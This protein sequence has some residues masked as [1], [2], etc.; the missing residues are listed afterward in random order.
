MQSAVRCGWR[1]VSRGLPVAVGL[2]LAIAGAPAPA[3]ADDVLTPEI[4][5]ASG[6]PEHVVAKR[7]RKAEAVAGS[8]RPSITTKGLEK[9]QLGARWSATAT[10]GPGLTQGD[11]TVLTW[12]IVPDGTSIFGYAGE[13]T[14]ASNLQADLNGI[15][16]NQATWL[17]LFQQV[18]DR[19]SDLTG[20]TYVYEPN[21][22]GSPWTQTSIAGGVLG[23][24]GDVRIAGHAIDGTNGIL[25]YN[26][27]PNI[28]DMVIDT[29]DNNFLNTAN[30]SRLLRNVVAHEH[31]HGM[32]MS[33]VCPVNQT[34]LMEPFLSLAFDGPQ[35]DDIHGAQRHYGDS[36][37][38]NDTAGTATNLG[39]F[40][41]SDSLQIPWRSVDD[42]SDVN[43]LA[44]SVGAFNSV[45][46]N[47]QPV[48]ATYLQGPQN[49]NGTCTAGTSFNSLTIHDLG[50]EV[51][52]TDGV[53]VLAV[54]NANP[55]GQPE[56]LSNLS[57]PSGSG[58]YFLRTFGGATNNAQLY[59]L[60]LSVDGPVCGNGVLESGEVCDGAD[61]GGQTCVSQGF[62][63]GVLS[64]NAGCSAFVTS[65]CFDCREGRSRGRLNQ[66]S[67]TTNGAAKGTHY[68]AIG[69]PAY[70]LSATLVETSAAG[71]TL[72][73]TMW[74][75]LG[76]TALYTFSGGWTRT[77]ANTGT[78]WAYIY[79]IVTN[80]Q[81]GKMS[82]TWTDDPSLQIGGT[83]DGSWK[84]C[85]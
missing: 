40:N 80:A 37:E 36:F 68:D 50:F 79:D 65:G 23:V 60:D 21:D 82:G 6:T 64:C 49:A 39:A 42:N 41:P 2:W 81:V 78:Y 29:A 62:D 24:R 57:L 16:G 1:R 48:G 32:G 83:F 12:S 30:N 17:A 73:G 85:D 31:G 66:A 8:L 34:K 76:T 38:H 33:H 46:V 5:F 14:A 19:W 26:F 69:N 44:F 27:F 11:P 55:A 52:D 70:T 51:L 54:A 72:T 4:C 20:I 71:G 75:P 18:F 56:S 13:P 77:T 35:L 28:G 9:F 10:N 67:G 25:A 59:Q 43:F 61:L 53:T 15:Y 22:D 58:T 47:L 74:P 63:G 3:Q 7:L 45:S 84:I